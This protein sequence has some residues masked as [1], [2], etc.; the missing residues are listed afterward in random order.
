M[1]KHLTEEQVERFG[2]D[3]FVF[4]MNAISALEA[5]PRPVFLTTGDDTLLS[6]PIEA[7][8]ALFAALR[9]VHWG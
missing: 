6:Y 5:A 1:P 3:G 2:R 7:T 9:K 4:P 8:V